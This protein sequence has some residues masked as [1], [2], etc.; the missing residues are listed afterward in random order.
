MK[1]EEIRSLAEMANIPESY[2]VLATMA[3]AQSRAFI[4]NDIKEW[5]TTELKNAVKKCKGDRDA[6]GSNA[7]GSGWNSLNSE[8]YRFEGKEKKGAEIV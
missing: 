6:F 7:G 5:P 3:I 8:A 4:K 2:D 1:L